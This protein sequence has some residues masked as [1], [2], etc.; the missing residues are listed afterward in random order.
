[1]TIRVVLADDHPIF[2]DGLERL[3]NATGEFEVTASCAS[4]V[5]ALDAVESQAPDIVVVDLRMPKLSGLDLLREI[6]QR[7][8]DVRVVILTAE[9]S[10]RELLEAVRLKA[11]GVVLKEMA[12]R[13]LLQCLHKVHQGGQWLEHRSMHGAFEAVLR[14]EAGRREAE[15]QL[16]PREIELVCMVADG[17]RNREIAE[18]LNITEGTVKTHVRNIYKKLG[19]ETRVAIRRYAEE[20]GLI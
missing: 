18:R 14:R 15:Q 5:D 16:T 20:H 19:C 8:L 9:L 11:N 13:L 6:R 3:L 12:P 17:L 7:R 10:E 2:L 4:G 1:V